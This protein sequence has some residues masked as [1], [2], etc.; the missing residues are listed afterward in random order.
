MANKR[1]SVVINGAGGY[2]SYRVKAKDWKQ[3]EEIAREMHK[4]DCPEDPEWEI[5]CAAVVSGWPSIWC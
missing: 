4:Q 3:A 5:G 2:S 1:F